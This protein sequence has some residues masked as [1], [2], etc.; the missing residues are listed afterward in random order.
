MNISDVKD[1]EKIPE[2]IWKEIFS[3]Q[4]EL[5]QKY[6]D[7]EGMGNLLETIDN[8]INTSKGQKWIKDFAWRVTEELA[9]A[10]EAHEL[11]EEHLSHEE[12]G[13]NASDYYTHYLEEL[14][15]A[16]H[17]LVELTIIAGYVNFQPTSSV[18]PGTTE[19]WDVVFPL[20]LMCNTLKNKPWKQTQMLT[21]RSDF[22][23]YLNRAWDYLIALFRQEKLKNE[24]IYN[25][26]FKKNSVNQFRIRSKY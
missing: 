9:E 8:N 11:M 13:P 15:D 2:D 14:I 12:G 4:M 19:P 18:T 6:K 1:T 20:G 3:K 16:L 5:A 10:Q 23:M 24:D 17:F 21:D 26:Y 7:I 22:E 25:L